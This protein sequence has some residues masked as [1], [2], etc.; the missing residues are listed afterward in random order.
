[1]CNKLGTWVGHCCAVD[2]LSAAQSACESYASQTK[3]IA[4]SREVVCQRDQRRQPNAVTVSVCYC[5]PLVVFAW[6]SLAVFSSTSK[7]DVADVGSLN[8]ANWF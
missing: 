7:P 8:F 6:R 5:C 2:L 1:M 3:R 4:R